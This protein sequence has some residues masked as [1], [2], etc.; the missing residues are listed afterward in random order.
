MTV[1]F[2]KPQPLD[3][4]RVATLMREIDRRECKAVGLSPW[5][6]LD[7][8]VDA[9]V[10]C[11]TGEVDGFPHAMFGVVPSSAATGIGSP[12]FLGSEEARKNARLFLAEAPKYLAQI[13][14]IF[15]RLEGRVHVENQAG[16]RWLLR[17]GFRVDF[18]YHTMNGEPLFRFTK[19][20]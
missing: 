20:F 10:L 12:W 15:P 19:G 18:R 8:A 9:S 1:A 11:W 14:A 13:E 16:H 5:G 3:V 4:E 2:R 6:A 7:G 17:M